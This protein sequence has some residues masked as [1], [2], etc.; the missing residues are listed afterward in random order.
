MTKQCTRCKAFKPFSAF[1]DFTK[2]GICHACARRGRIDWA[3]DLTPAHYKRQ[4]EQPAPRQ[5]GLTSNATAYL[6]VINR[7]E[8][9]V[10]G[11]KMRL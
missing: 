8:A 7:Y 6:V 11:R 9:G 10:S 3:Y 1:S 4:P 2:N 5:D